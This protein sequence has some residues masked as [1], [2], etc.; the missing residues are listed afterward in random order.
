MST[1]GPYLSEILKTLL[2]AHNPSMPGHHRH[3]LLFLPKLETR[4][5]RYYSSKHF[6]V[7]SLR[8]QKQFFIWLLF[9]R[10]IFESPGNFDD[11]MTLANLLLKGAYK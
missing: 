1:C 4:R 8:C 11:K 6:R 10:L 2:L 7:H 9:D 3:I 5:I